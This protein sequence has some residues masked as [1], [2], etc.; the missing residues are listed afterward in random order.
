MYLQG[1]PPR[2]EGQGVLASGDNAGQFI[3]ASGGLIQL[4]SKAPSYTYT[5]VDT[6]TGALMFSN[7]DV[8]PTGSGK[9]SFTSSDKTLNWTSPDGKVYTVSTMGSIRDTL[10]FHLRRP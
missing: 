9:F 8:P 4:T 6:T 7:G 10:K 2:S 5:H 3:I 1:S